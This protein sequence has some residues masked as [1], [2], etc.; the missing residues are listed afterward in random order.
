MPLRALALSPAGRGVRT[1]SDCCLGGSLSESSDTLRATVCRTQNTPSGTRRLDGMPNA[2]D[3]SHIGNG[4]AV[5][6]ATF[7][8]RGSNVQFATRA[9]TQQYEILEQ[10]A[11]PAG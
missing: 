3:Q 10:I 6:S 8:A 4:Q 2:D 9:F 11:H 5:L 1:G 7:S